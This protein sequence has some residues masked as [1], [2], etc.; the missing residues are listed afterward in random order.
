MIPQKRI[1]VVDDDPDILEIIQDRLESYGFAVVTASNGLEAL[2]KLRKVKVHGVLLDIR[3]PVMDGMET[4]RVIRQDYPEL[5][6]IMITASTS[7]EYASASLKEGAQDYLLKPFNYK[8]L[9][10][11]IE[12]YL[13]SP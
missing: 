7:K 13:D 3:M 11:K 4:L 8:L 12:H 2:E 6:V 9:R 1:L 5:P 10:E